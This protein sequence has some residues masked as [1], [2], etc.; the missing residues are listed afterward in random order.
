MDV[1]GIAKFLVTF[2]IYL[3]IQSSDILL[4]AL[5]VNNSFSSHHNGVTKQGTMRLGNITK[6]MQLLSDRVET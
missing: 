3:I 1:G 2:N 4:R 5:H 6:T